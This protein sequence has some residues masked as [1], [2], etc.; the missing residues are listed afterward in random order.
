MRLHVPFML[1]TTALIGLNSPVMAHEVAQQQYNMVSI[2]ASVSR[3]IANDEMQ[4]TLSIEK[5]HKSPSELANQINQLMNF[6]IATA[7]KYP[8]VK[9]KTGQQSTTPIYDDNNRKIKDWRAYA[10]VQLESQDIEATSKLIAELQQH[11]QLENV[12]FS[13]SE[14]QRK[15]VEDELLLEV[16]K[17]FQHRANLIR[18]AWNKSSYDLVSFNVDTHNQYIAVPMMAM[19]SSARQKTIADTQ[20]MNVGESTISMNAHGQIQLK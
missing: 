16:S 15:K 19:A 10:N 6:A 20:E 14:Q 4:A 2:Q 17:N 3:Q 12:N 5:T 18:Q 7:K 8:T 11:F 13:V 1:L 9:I